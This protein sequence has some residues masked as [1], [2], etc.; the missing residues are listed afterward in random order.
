MMLEDV[1]DNL[2]KDNELAAYKHDGFWYGMDTQRDK[3]Q[4]EEMWKTG[5]AKWKIW[6]D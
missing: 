6:E 1:L 3:L 2:A 4:L 5:N